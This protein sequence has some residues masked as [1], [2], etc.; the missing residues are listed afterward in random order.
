M[1]REALVIIVIVL[2]ARGAAFVN[3]KLFLHLV[4]SYGEID[5]KDT[6]TIRL[7]HTLAGPSH[8]DQFFATRI[9]KIA[10]KIG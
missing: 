4:L 3:T 8:W 6:R 10:A 1:L 9:Q 5:R 2:R 7:E